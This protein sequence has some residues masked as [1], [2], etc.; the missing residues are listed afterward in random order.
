MGGIGRGWRAEKLA[1]PLAGF[2]LVRADGRQ[3]RAKPNF[4][5]STGG[6]IGLKPDLHEHFCG[7]AFA[8]STGKSC[9]AEA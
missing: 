1:R 7:F 2:R 6:S 4:G 3:L 5:D 8:D 9:Q